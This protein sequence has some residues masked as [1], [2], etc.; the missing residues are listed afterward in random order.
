[1]TDPGYLTIRSASIYLDGISETTLREAAAKGELR[2]AR[3]GTP[4]DPGTT[5]RRPIRIK[6]EDL[7]A[8]VESQM[9]G[10]A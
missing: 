10:A 8:W 6:R 9:G 5:D 3:F 4:P 2:H 7:D 1:M